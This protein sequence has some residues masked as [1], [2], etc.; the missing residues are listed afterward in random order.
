MQ[1]SLSLSIYIYI[2]TYIGSSFRPIT[3]H[4]CRGEAVTALFAYGAGAMICLISCTGVTSY[5]RVNNLRTF[6][7]FTKHSM[8]CQ[9][10]GLNQVKL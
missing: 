10:H 5:Y 6:Q 8:I 3:I 2:Y 7:Q 1:Q 4:T 9:L